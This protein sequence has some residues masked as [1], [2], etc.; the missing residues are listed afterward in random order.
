MQKNI[1]KT[2]FVLA[3]IASELVALNC[4]YLEENT[5]YR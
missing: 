4:L 1:D 2:L 5:C 3:K